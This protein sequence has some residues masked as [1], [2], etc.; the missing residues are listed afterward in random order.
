MRPR[1]VLPD[2]RSL[3]RTEPRHPLPMLR[4][5]TAPE[6]AE[7]LAVSLRTAQRIVRE[8]HDQRTEHATVVLRP[9]GRTGTQSVRAVRMFVAA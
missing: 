4:T 8:H 3:E 5:L 2:R 7:A 9:Q 6:L 1:Y